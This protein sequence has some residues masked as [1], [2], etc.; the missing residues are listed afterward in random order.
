MI[1]LDSSVVFSS[2]AATERSGE[3]MP[4]PGHRGVVLAL[5]GANAV[6][7]LKRRGL[8]PFRGGTGCWGSTGRRWAFAMAK[9]TP[10]RVVVERGDALGA[11]TRATSRATTTP[12]C[13]T[14]SPTSAPAF[15]SILATPFQ[16]TPAVDTNVSSWTIGPVE[17]PA[18]PSHHPPRRLLAA[19]AHSLT[20]L[21]TAHAHAV[22]SVSASVSM[23][24]WIH[25]PIPRSRSPLWRPVLRPATPSMPVSP[26]RSK[27]MKP[28]PSSPS[29]ST[30]RVA[31]ISD[32][33]AISVA[34]VFVARDDSPRVLAIWLSMGS[35]IPSSDEE[36]NLCTYRARQA[37]HRATS[38][39][40]PLAGP[41]PYRRPLCFPRLLDAWGQTSSRPS[42]L[43]LTR[44]PPPS[45]AAAVSSPR[46]PRCAAEREEL[47]QTHQA[48]PVPTHLRQLSTRCT[49][50]VVPGAPPQH[51]RLRAAV[52]AANP[53]SRLHSGRPRTKT[54]P[55]SSWTHPAPP[56]HASPTVLIAA[57]A[58][59]G[60][61]VDY[62]LQS[63][64]ARTSFGACAGAVLCSFTLLNDAWAHA[65]PQTPPPLSHSCRPHAHASPPPIFDPYNIGDGL[66]LCVNRQAAGRGVCAAHAQAAHLAISVRPS[67]APAHCAGERA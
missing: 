42:S 67:P 14:I 29:S 12:P 10:S 3:E 48:V 31:A 24:A 40:H 5:G 54:P 46:T 45:R 15:A 1:A 7:E 63:P 43:S 52:T 57:I 30:I 2:E 18:T 47:R 21:L 17:T 56:P 38:S 58:D 66:V 41:V 34:A 26:R 39:S 20:A 55:A 59:A 44:S 11:E 9:T 36:E 25:R 27:T 32:T 19:L 28:P 61:H 65:R 37:V 64:S 60:D 62:M 51:R 22:A 49:P 33:G 8:A 23:A 13:F 50:A 53:H 35:S 16:P 4:A 6:L